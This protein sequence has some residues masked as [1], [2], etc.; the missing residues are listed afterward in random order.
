MRISSFNVFFLCSHPIGRVAILLALCVITVQSSLL[1][2][3]YG[4]W[5]VFKKEMFVRKER[6][7]EKSSISISCISI[8]AKEVCTGQT[9]I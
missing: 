2:N 1:C 5:Q 9:G 6:W 8:I 7:K 3:R 4:I